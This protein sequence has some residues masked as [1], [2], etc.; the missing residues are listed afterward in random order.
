MN[1]PKCKSK[2]IRIDRTA[3]VFAQ[4]EYPAFMCDYAP[5]QIPVKFETIMTCN[6]CNTKTE[7]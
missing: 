4:A 6:D 7:L 3:V 2:N 1:C 5:I